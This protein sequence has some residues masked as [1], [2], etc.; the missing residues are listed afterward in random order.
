MASMRVSAR[1][2]IETLCRGSRGSGFVSLKCS[3]LDCEKLTYIVY[4]MISQMTSPGQA[5]SPVPRTEEALAS[6]GVPGL[7]GVGDHPIGH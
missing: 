5:L 4:P 7:Q 1:A 2:P 6:V 3:G